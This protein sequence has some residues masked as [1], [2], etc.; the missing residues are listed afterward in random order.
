MPTTLPTATLDE[1]AEYLVS[2]YWTPH[3]FDTS[4]SNEITV[5]VTGLN[6]DGR[7]L[8]RW[9]MDAWSAVADITFVETIGSAQIEFR[10]SQAGAYA[11]SSY[12]N[13][14]IGSAYVNISRTWIDAYGATIDSYGF[15]TYLHELGHALGLGHPGD[16]NG[17]AEHAEDAIFA[18]DSW[19]ISVMSYFD[20]TE[21]PNITASYG[22]VLTPMMADIL[23][24]QMLYG[25]PDSD[26]VSAGDTT[27]GLGS[28]LGT[29][30]GPWFALVAENRTD[31]DLY[32]GHA[33][34]LTL[35]DVGGRDLVDLSFSP[36]DMS[37]D[38][39]PGQFSDVAGG[40]GNVG[41]AQ[42]TVLE[43]LRAGSGDD[44]LVGN[45][46]NNLIL[47]N[48]GDDTLQGMNGG[49]TLN[50]GAG[51][52]RLQ[53]GNQ[54]DVIRGGAGADIA[55]GGNGRDT[56]WLGAGEDIFYD[57][58]Q[59]GV[60][61]GDAAHGG[62]GNDTLNGGGG[63]DTLNGGGGQDSVS[64]GNQGDA[65]YGG[66]GGDRIA[67]GAGADLL[68]GGRQ[69]DRLWGGTGNDTVLGS[70]GSDQAWLGDGHDLYEDDDQVD[71]GHDRI[72]AGRG[73]DTILLG[74]GDD[75]VTGGGGADSFVFSSAEGDDLVTDYQPGIDSLTFAEEIWNGGLSALQ[76]ITSFAEVTDGS[77]V[78]TFEPGYSVTL[79]GVTG[80]ADIIGDIALV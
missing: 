49:D 48:A 27:W 33:V 53:G 74:G 40:I 19:Q 63:Q 31:A 16:Y 13:G 69:N 35:Y 57:S 70:N 5:N 68:N 71:F 23:A 72:W 30:L 51:D 10:D 15:S 43:D 25:P 54:N 4:S 2:G 59:T 8:A 29:Y 14:V 42:G 26:S 18:N 37:I 1:F 78:F 17:N 80:T 22:D 6:G 62:A 79:A 77:L 73:N 45:S 3:A 44:L 21:N 56:V 50:G 9:A 41:I 55:F 52:D 65:L 38:L 60:Y 75:T 20:Q 11:G 76:V 66:D 46:A 58:A 47:G 61:G 28:T 24:I 67:G 7:Q 64:G 34:A 36:D 32:L 39:R 12:S